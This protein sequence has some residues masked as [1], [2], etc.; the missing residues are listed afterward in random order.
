MRKQ[1]IVQ[2]PRRRGVIVVFA[3][4]L[5]IPLLGLVAL[6]VDYGYL[7]VVKTDL[8]R[9]ADAAALAAVR[10][11]VPNSNGV[12]DLDAVKATLRQYAAANV[13]NSS[14]FTVLDS[15]IE[16][17]RYD[18][19]TVYTNFTIL[20]T[21]T[22]DTVRVTLRR[23][24]QANSPVSLFF[25][26]LLGF[27]TSN[28]S[29][30]ATAVLQKASILEAGTE[31]LPFS[32]QD[33][34]WTSQSMGD[35]WSIYG[36]GRILDSLGGSIPGNWGTL[37]IGAG[38]NST[39]DLSDQILNGLRQSDLDALYNDGRIPSSSEID[40]TDPWF[41]NAD[42]GLSAGIKNAIEQVHGLT[43]LVPIYD[44][45]SGSGG[46]NV[47]FHIV[48]WGVVKVVG[49]GWNGSSNSYVTIQKSY[50]YDQNL[51]PQPDLSNTTGVIEG[52]YTSPVLVR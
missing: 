2:K 52:A 35:Q 26:R 20:S 27:N 44:T 1:T 4:L 6:A 49:S 7:C 17:G 50:T 42:T 11:L 18:P 34:V 14:G 8:Q 15:D 25:A 31:I 10:D 5:M 3:A 45:V 38:N 30:T 13:T 29:A 21:G 41:A 28:V 46:N 37:D 23:D 22:F 12:Q 40:S 32:I 36:D 19:A 33:G 47:E 43:R 39:A 24:T 16:I 51:R 48:S 9:S